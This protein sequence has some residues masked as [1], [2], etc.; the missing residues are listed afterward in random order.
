MT[1]HSLCG[2]YPAASCYWRSGTGLTGWHLCPTAHC[3]LPQVDVD[4]PTYAT[5]TDRVTATIKANYALG[6]PV[7]GQATIAIYPR[8][9]SGSLQPIFSEPLRQ[10][11]D[12]SGKVDVEFELA[13]ELIAASPKLVATVSA[14]SWLG[15]L[16]SAII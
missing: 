1:K 13:K 8:S 14:V 6:R 5:F 15:P 2:P 4:I 11:V 7:K 3:I 12:I 9:K 10:V 16:V